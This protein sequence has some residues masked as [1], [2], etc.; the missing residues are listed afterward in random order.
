MA[1]T[2]TESTETVDITSQNVSKIELKIAYVDGAIQEP[3]PPD[4]VKNLR[5]QLRDQLNELVSSENIQSVA[6]SF[7]SEDN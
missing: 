2:K 4:F 7:Q 3:L 6:V 1:E 5:N